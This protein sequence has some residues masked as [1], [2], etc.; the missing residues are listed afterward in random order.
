[1]E[2]LLLNAL[3]R[4]YDEALDVV[5]PND[6]DTH[7]ARSVAWMNAIGATFSQKYGEDQS[8]RVFWKQ[9]D[10]HKKDF[11]LNELLHDLLVAK[12]AECASP[13]R[14]IPIS[15]ITAVP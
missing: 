11:G 10:Q 13:K 2:T 4:A 12:C 8:I 9:N 1:V 15:Y 3:E 14:G 6:R 7:R 5:Y